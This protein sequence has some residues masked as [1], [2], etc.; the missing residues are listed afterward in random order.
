LPFSLLNA[1][2]AISK[3]HQERSSVRI[4]ASFWEARRENGRR[5]RRNP[6]PFSFPPM[7]KNIL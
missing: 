6:N 5:K 3:I 7:G 2:F 1:Q 4:A